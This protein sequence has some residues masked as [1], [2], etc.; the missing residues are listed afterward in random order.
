M[1]TSLNKNY[2]T[3]TC[4]TSQSEGDTL[5]PS[6]ST[7]NGNAHDVLKTD[8]EEEHNKLLH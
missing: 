7:S 6:S 2:E 5:D 1:G 8:E 4:Y 3:G